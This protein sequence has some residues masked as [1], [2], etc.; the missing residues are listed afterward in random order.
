MSNRVFVA[1]VWSFFLTHLVL[2]ECKWRKDRVVGKPV[3][4]GGVAGGLAM[5]FGCT[6][7]GV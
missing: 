1:K 3:W 4:G 6:E 5:W 7:V 2:Y